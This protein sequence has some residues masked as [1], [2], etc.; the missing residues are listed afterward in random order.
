MDAVVDPAQQGDRF[1]VL[2]AAELVGEPLAGLPRVVVVEHRGDGVDPEAVDVVLVEPEQGVRGQEVD[3][4]GLAEVED[5]RVPFELPAAAGVGVLVKVRAVEE[6]QAVLVVGEVRGDPVEDHAQPALVEGVDQEHEVVRRAEPAGRGEVAGGLIPPRAVE[7][8][9][10]DRHQLDVGVPHV[11]GV[12]GEPGG[13]LAVRS[14]SGPPSSAAHP[15]AEV[16]LVNRDRRGDGVRARG[17][18]PSR[19]R[20]PRRS[21]RGRRPCEAVPGRSSAANP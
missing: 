17:G 16:D 13:K 20:R 7:R 3:D 1:E 2:T 10:G 18:R 9:L 21:R 19:R 5:R 4:P 8:V 11:G 15:R 12:V 14:A 6:G